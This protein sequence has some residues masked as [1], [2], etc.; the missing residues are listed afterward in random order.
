MRGRLMNVPGIQALEVNS[1][2]ARTAS[3]S[4]DYA[5]TLGKL[6]KELEKTAFP[7]R[8]ARKALFSAPGNDIAEDRTLRL[9]IC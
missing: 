6:Q 8:T 3:I 2:S 5:G 7:S 1:L 4:F 9:E